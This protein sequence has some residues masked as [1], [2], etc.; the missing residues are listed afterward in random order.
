MFRVGHMSNFPCVFMR[1]EVKQSAAVNLKKLQYLFQGNFDFVVEP[2]GRQVDEP[3]RKIRNQL[4]KPEA[5]FQ[6]MSEIDFILFQ[7]VT[8]YYPSS[9]TLVPSTSNNSQM[10]REFH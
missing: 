4:F 5:L 9:R 7:S 1:Q 3:C 2:L 8:I 6:F 10:Y